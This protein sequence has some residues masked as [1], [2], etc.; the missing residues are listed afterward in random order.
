M[1]QPVGFAPFSH[2]F[3]TKQLAAYCLLLAAAM[4]GFADLLSLCRRTILHKESR[5]QPALAN[6]HGLCSMAI[7]HNESKF[8]PAVARSPY[9]VWRYYTIRV[10]QK[11]CFP[12]VAHSMPVKLLTRTRVY[13]KSW[14]VVRLLSLVAC[15]I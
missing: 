14:S 9:V 13:Q 3:P 2:G 12:T 7:L 4:L 10:I 8:Q 5:F 15:F 6:L 1:L 11:R